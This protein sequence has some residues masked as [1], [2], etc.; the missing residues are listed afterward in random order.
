[1]RFDPKLER[2]RY[3]TDLVPR[4][5][6]GNPSGIFIIPGPHGTPLTIIADDGAASG[7]EHV[8]VA[9]HKAEAFKKPRSERM[10]VQDQRTPDWL[11]MC[12]VKNLLWSEEECVV[13]FH[14]PQSNYV[15]SHPHVLHLWRWRHGDFPRPPSHLV[16][17]LA[18]KKSPA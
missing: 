1:M 8:S 6:P 9:A 17:S 5:E 2:Y 13:Q 18:S 11:E 7:W 15:N 10:G 14:P 3:N 4:N 12:H 16:G